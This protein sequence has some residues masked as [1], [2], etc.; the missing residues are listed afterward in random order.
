[1]EKLGKCNPEL[2][3]H[4][5]CH[6]ERI[7]H[8][9]GIQ[10]KQIKNQWGMVCGWGGG[11]GRSERTSGWAHDTGRE[12]QAQAPALPA[13][14]IFENLYTVPRLAVRSSHSGGNSR[15]LYMGNDGGPKR[16][17]RMLTGAFKQSTV[18]KESH[19]CFWFSHSETLT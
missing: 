15:L 4:H 12:A 5:E 16:G 11:G 10:A 9:A 13:I 6:A 8:R 17:M 2:V 18:A 14:A 3:M 7:Q 19:Y 1:M